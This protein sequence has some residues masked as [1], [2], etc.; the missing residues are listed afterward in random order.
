MTGNGRYRWS[1]RRLMTN[2]E[3][4]LRSWIAWIVAKA[5]R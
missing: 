3:L 4:V 5:Q 1:N 2:S